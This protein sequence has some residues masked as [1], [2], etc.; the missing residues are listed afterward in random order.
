MKQVLIFYV[1]IGSGHLSAARAI[2]AA[3]KLR[4][5]EIKADV[6]D[7]FGGFR[8]LHRIPDALSAISTMVIPGIYDWSWRTGKMRAFFQLSVWMPGLRKRVADLLKQYQPDAVVCTHA[9]PCAIMAQPGYQKAI[10]PLLAA[11]TDFD[12]HPYWPVHRVDAFVVASPQAREHLIQRGYPI[13]KIHAYGIPVNPDFA[14]MMGD[15]RNETGSIRL[16]MLAG[17]G[18]RGP[19][20][21]I[22]GKVRAIMDILAAAPVPG[23]E[24]KII[25]GKNDALL[26][27]ARRMLGNRE[28]I[29]LHSFLPDLHA[30]L[31]NADL[32]ITKSGGLA[33][34]EALA[35]G[36][37]LL[38]LQRG[39]GQEHA[40]TTTVLTANAGVML[41]SP[42][43][44][45]RLIQE[46]KKNPAQLEK[47]K[48]NARALGAPQ[49][50]MQTA[51]LV[52]KL[53]QYRD[54]DYQ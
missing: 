20:L 43:D 45:F 14:K 32:L 44:L 47:L 12:V 10:P 30:H 3:L 39:A 19:Y 15:E 22:I 2:Q 9:L 11:A 26:H 40:N 8:R 28:D 42:E 5:P 35:L 4:S 36:K 24:W 52:E 37:P 27:Q 41:E 53:I 7:L 13:E 48:S 29:E 18:S 1:S 49:A 25:F 34:A 50:A 46:F 23:V 33:L 16:L 17:G 21:P 6:E 38:L 51:E 54:A 31:A